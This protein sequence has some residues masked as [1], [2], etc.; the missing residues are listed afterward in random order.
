MS[1]SFCKSSTS[2]LLSINSSS[3]RRFFARMWACLTTPT[4][5]ENGF[6]DLAFDGD[7]DETAR[8][9]RRVDAKVAKS[10]NCCVF[11]FACDYWAVE[12]AMGGAVTESLFSKVETH[13]QF[14][15]FT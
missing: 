6:D 2:M 1:C 8:H 4:L 15:T 3:A 7:I 14:Q 5:A 11:G 12:R 10:T 9:T 13:I